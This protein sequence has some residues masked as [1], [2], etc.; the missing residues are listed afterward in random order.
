MVVQGWGHRMRRAAASLGALLVVGVVAPRSGRA[1]TYAA[2]A[3]EA[4]TD[5]RDVRF[6][7]RIDAT[8][9]V[10]LVHRTYPGRPPIR[11]D[12][13]DG[14][15]KLLLAYVAQGF[16]V[17]NNGTACPPTLPGRALLHA[18]TDKVVFSVVYHCAADLDVLTMKSA[19][20]HEETTPHQ[21]IGTFHHIRALEHYFFTPGMREAVIPTRRLA[22]VMPSVMTGGGFHMAPPP[23]GAFDPKP[24][25]G[26]GFVT[27]IGQGV[28]HILSGI[29]HL[30]FIISLLIVIRDWKQLAA[31]VT[32]F[33]IA[34]SVTLALGALGLARISPR[35]VE[36]MIA[37]S[38][39]YVAIENVARLN[40]RARLG[41]TFAFGLVHGFGFSSVLR[42][43][44]LA[45]GQLVPA[46]LGFNLGVELGQLMVVAPLFPLVMW[47]QRRADVYRRVRLS[48]NASVA[49]IACWWFVQRVIGSMS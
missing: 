1:H 28:M 26:N 30:L 27:F 2:S 24:A 35:L 17:A 15:S 21:I 25:T 19:L 46:L 14:E 5:G 13:I 29:D 16:T 38:I 10:E 8:S 6:D 40:P 4:F 36:P 48:L 37:L 33:T 31:V 32:S 7:F 34:H 45:R 39:I 11:R 41:V 47:L 3:F 18:Q 22:Q 42:D 43:L 20:F 44:G 9:V 23:P 12:G 49:V